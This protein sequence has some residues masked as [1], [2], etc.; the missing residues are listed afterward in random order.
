ML[1]TQYPWLTRLGFQYTAYWTSFLFLAVVANLRWLNRAESAAPAAAAAAEVR[2]SRQAWKVAMAAATLV[3]CYQL[4]PVFQQNTSWAGFLPMRVEITGADRLR[5]AN[6]Y[7]LIDEIP[8]DA[9]VAAAEM[10]V[11]HVSSRKNAYTLLHGHYDADYILARIP[12]APA[13]QEHLIAALRT[14]DYGLVD[15]KGVFALFRRGA[16]AATAEPFL[17]RIGAKPEV[18][19]K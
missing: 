17:L 11:A 1:A 12:P 18:P 2:R 4:G 7:A 8:P 9:S 14:G 16:P 3:T 6:L 5:H 19:I 15:E 10:L 13:D